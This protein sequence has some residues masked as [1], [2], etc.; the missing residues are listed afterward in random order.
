MLISVL[1]DKKDDYDALLRYYHAHGNHKT[2]NSSPDGF[3]RFKQTT[4]GHGVMTEA[5]GDGGATD[6][7]L[8]VALSFLLAGELLNKWLEAKRIIILGYPVR[9]TSFSYIFLNV[10]FLSSDGSWEGPHCW[11]KNRSRNSS[12][13]LSVRLS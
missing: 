12:N 2:V 4:N 10:S 9:I 8:D 3:M 13:L 11:D 6:A 7:E 5:G 1:M